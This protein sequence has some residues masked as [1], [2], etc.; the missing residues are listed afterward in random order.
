ARAAADAGPLDPGVT[1]HLHATDAETD[2]TA[3]E[4]MLRRE[5]A[6]V[7]LS[8]GHGKATTAVRGRAVDL[9]LALTRRRSAEDAGLEVLGDPAVWEGWLARTPY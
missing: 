1:L 9:L 2:D 7:S 5:P 6:G 8:A 4:W 3:G